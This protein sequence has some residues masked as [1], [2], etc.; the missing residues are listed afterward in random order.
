LSE[1]SPSLLLK[2]PYIFGEDSA[3]CFFFSDNVVGSTPEARNLFDALPRL[4]N[5]SPAGGTLANTIIALGMAGL[6]ES[7]KVPLLKNIANDKYA[8]ALRSINHAI[9]DPVLSKADETLL[10]VLL[11]GMYEEVSA[12]VQSAFIGD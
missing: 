5:A 4:F 12:T 8:I 11:L 1:S 3:A 2:E 9:A 6:S 7:M 10:I